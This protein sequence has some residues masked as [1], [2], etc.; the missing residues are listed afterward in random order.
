M[1]SPYLPPG[2]DSGTP[3]ASGDG[4]SEPQAPRRAAAPASEPSGYTPPGAT[5][6]GATPSRAHPSDQAAPAASV[7]PG[8]T[9]PAAGYTPPGAASAPAPG[10]SASGYTPPSVGGPGPV[11]RRSAPAA[12]PATAPAETTA[13]LPV[14][15]GPSDPD[16]GAP[17]ATPSRP[18]IPKLAL[19]VGAVVVLAVAGLVVAWLLGAFAP[20]MSRLPAR[21]GDYAMDTSTRKSSAGVYDSAVYRAGEGNIVSASILKGGDPAADYAG[22]S[23]ASRF[24]VG[25]VYCTGVS[26]SGKG[27]SC[28]LKLPTGSVVRVDASTR[29]TAKEIAQF[30]TDVAAGVT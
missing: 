20:K 29:H 19:I 17:P 13:V 15:P 5:P 23:A 3:G 24:A 2:R 28:Q 16:P 21:A 8:S 12:A 25:E 9:P 10:A 30:A 26:K 4:S 1:S 22:A 7:P 27:G 14:A 11:G 6:P 18:G